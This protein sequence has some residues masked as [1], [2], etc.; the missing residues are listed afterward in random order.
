MKQASLNLLYLC[1][2]L[3][4]LQLPAQATE[5]PSSDRTT[6]K[7]CV[8]TLG[9][10]CIGAA[11]GL[12]GAWCVSRLVGLEYLYT[13][14]IAYVLTFLGA[15]VTP[16]ATWQALLL[17]TS[18]GI[19][20]FLGAVRNELQAM[21]ALF[22]KA[23][24]VVESLRR[25]NLS[26]EL[27]VQNQAT[28]DVIDE[29]AALLV[30]QA[31]WTPDQV[32]HTLRKELWE[33]PDAIQ[34]MTDY[35]KA[36]K[37]PLVGCQDFADDWCDRLVSPLQNQYSIWE[38]DRDPCFRNRTWWRD[39]LLWTIVLYGLYRAYGWCLCSLLEIHGTTAGVEQDAQGGGKKAALHLSELPARQVGA[40]QEDGV[41]AAPSR[42]ERADKEEAGSTV[43]EQPAVP[44][45][46]PSPQ[47]PKQATPWVLSG[48]LLGMVLGSTCVGAI[49]HVAQRR[50]EGSCAAAQRE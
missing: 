14:V 42:S 25:A 27:G 32:I 33:I 47:G 1:C 5:T 50:V 36:S 38:S 48:L 10:G 20:C 7:T 45:N 18:F 24:T 49:R 31:F 35:E 15:F 41:G 26:P 30:S 37:I 43:P 19:L 29:T 34:Y 9:Q 44:A 2:A 21:A 8:M 46:L 22:Q 4:A 23:F 3:G 11:V 16:S 13:S 40:L 12:T 39:T 6:L 28:L 17:G